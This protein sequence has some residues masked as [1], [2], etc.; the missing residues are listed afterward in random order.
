MTTSNKKFDYRV[1][2]FGFVPYPK[3]YTRAQAIAKMKR[4]KH[5]QTL[6]DKFDLDEEFV[7]QPRKGWI[8][9]V[10]N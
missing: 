10:E 4:N 7:V 1:K 3:M 2:G 9:I 6:I 5:F 8:L